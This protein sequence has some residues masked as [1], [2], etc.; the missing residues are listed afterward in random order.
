LLTETH[1]VSAENVRL[2]YAG[3]AVLDALRHTDLAR[4]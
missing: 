3:R 4:A 2:T 1:S